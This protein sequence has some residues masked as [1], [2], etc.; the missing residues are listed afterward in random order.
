[1]RV[2]ELLV[3]EH[4]RVEVVVDALLDNAWPV[5]LDELQLRVVCLDPFCLRSDFALHLTNFLLHISA[6]YA[7]QVL[8]LDHDSSEETQ[9]VAALAEANHSTNHVKLIALLRRVVDVLQAEVLRNCH[10]GFQ[11]AGAGRLDAPPKVEVVDLGV[12][13]LQQILVVALMS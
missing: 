7:D 2:L 8:D 9:V 3:K 13:I 4:L 11:D 1:M 12:R 6:S 5:A 10:K